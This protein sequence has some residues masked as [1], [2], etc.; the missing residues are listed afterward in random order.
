[1]AFPIEFFLLAVPAI[2]IAG[3]GKS[4]FTSGGGVIALVLMSLWVSPQVAAGIMLPLLVM[5]D[6]LNLWHYRKDWRWHWIVRFLPAAS[7]GILLGWFLFA[8]ISADGMRVAVGLL[9][10]FFV[11]RYLLE[12]LRR[13]PTEPLGKIGAQIMGFLSGLGSFIA[14]AGGPPADAYLLSQRIGKTEFVGT[15]IYL[16]FVIN[17]LKLVPYAMLGLFSAANLG[18][19]LAL[20]PVVPIGVFLGHYLHK[21]VSQ[22]LFERIAYFLLGLTGAKLLYDGIAGLL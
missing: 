11:A 3:I 10:F 21:R 1:M 4:G 9:A 15:S 19:S 8:Y 2:L 18:T 17:G 14:H 20:A 22:Q 16:F 5:M 7:V 6:V 13:A 12:N